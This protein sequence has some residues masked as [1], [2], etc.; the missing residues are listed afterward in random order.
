MTVATCVALTLVALATSGVA[1]G[2][3]GSD[4]DAPRV[5]PEMLTAAGWSDL[6][7]CVV[8]EIQVGADDEPLVSRRGRWV[9][10]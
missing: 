4:E 1:V 10:P 8:E 2:C 5:T 3:G 9:R 6:L 7:M